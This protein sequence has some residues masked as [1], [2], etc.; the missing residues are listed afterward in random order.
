MLS[1][2]V[3]EPF[4]HCNQQ[5][6]AALATALRL[7]QPVT[8]IKDSRYSCHAT[9]D[10]TSGRQEDAKLCAV[11]T[12][13]PPKATTIRMARNAVAPLKGATRVFAAMGDVAYSMQR[14]R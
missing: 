11:T 14:A 12:S 5:N 9:H 13:P 4:S 8:L 7:T 6:A 3:R 2:A 1:I 10:P